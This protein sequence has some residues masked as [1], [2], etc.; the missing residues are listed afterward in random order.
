MKTRIAASS[1]LLLLAV[2]AAPARAQV[3]GAK[4]GSSF[5]TISTDPDDNLNRKSLTAF[6]GGGLLRF[7]FIGL[8]L[9]L[10]ALALTKGEKI[11]DENTDA[12]AKL[13]ATYVEVPLTAMFSIGDGPYV[14][15]GPSV[16]FEADC[17]TV[18]AAN[19]NKVESDCNQNRKKTDW[20]VT[21]GAGVQFRGG[22]GYIL[23]EGR[24]TYGLTN[25]TAE[26]STRKSYN[27]SLAAF[28]G[29]AVYIG[30]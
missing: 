29:Y 17:K 4:L 10:E 15:V 1:F 11:V 12:T 3:I 30:D 25:I 18:L 26:T 6:G 8:T 21:G 2:T 23:L 7:G 14:F 20:G 27:R 19:N 24:Y 13:K 9:Q 28:I 5:S 16:A 22:P